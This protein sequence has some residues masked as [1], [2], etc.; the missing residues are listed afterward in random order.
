MSFDLIEALE[1]DR[2]EE[3]EGLISKAR[4]DYYNG[5]PSVE[6]RVYDAWVDELAELKEDSFQVTSVGAPAVSAWPKVDHE[7][8]MGSLNKVQTID[9]MT[10]W[11]QKYGRSRNQ[12]ASGHEELLVT[13][14]LDGISVSLKYVKGKFVQGVTRGDGHVG[15]DI[16]PNVARMKGVPHKLPKPITVMIRG[17]IVLFKDDLSKHFPGMANPRNAASGTAKRLDGQGSEHLTVVAYQALES[18]GQELRSEFEVFALLESLG[19]KVPNYFR[20]AVAFGVRTPQDIWVDY[21]QRVRESLPYEI[22]GLVVR[23]DDLAYQMSLG[24]KNDRP[25]GAVAF[26][27]SPMTREAKAI[28]RIDQVGGTGKI[29]PVAEFTPVRIMGAEVN[30]ASLYNQKYIEEIGFYEGARLLITRANDVIP[31]VVSVVRPH[32][33]GLVSQP[34]KECPECGSKTVRDGEYIV[35]PNV[36]GCPAQTEGRIRQWVK[37]L[38]ILEWG[39]T[40]VS[41]VVS[42]GLV[43]T[44]P[45]LYRLNASNLASLD[46]MGATSAKKAIEQLWSVVPM[47]LE[48]FLGALA[49]PL[50][51]T[52]TIQTVVDAGLDTLDAIR[53]ASVEQ[54]ASIPG[55]G[56]R[57]ATSLHNWLQSNG[58]VLDNLLGAG[59]S[60]KAKAVGPLSGK[61]V[62]FTGK[63]TMKRAEL[64]RLAEQAGGTVKKSVG[65]GLTYLVMSDPNSGSTKARAART[66]GVECL[67]EENFL[68][69]VGA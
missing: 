32:P 31:R 54:F 27:F 16:T 52:S 19:F 10:N 29:T 34:P 11:V 2:V 6:D 21:Q 48:Q 47:P 66:N 7:I 50:C 15:E 51:A 43:E 57:R 61:S 45:D 55:M 44:V 65:K 41:K 63:S 60:I 42:E 3:L 12:L 58:S 38:G 56:P 36:G 17:K 14:K 8:P 20:S 1:S 33:E 53:G 13:E 64:I 23:F 25:L 35:C 4:H 18:D 40:L 9:E 5:Q 49:I 59:V 62:C 69:L 67:S 37:E 26:K 28:R 24:E 68:H 46:R 30:R 39:P 22:D